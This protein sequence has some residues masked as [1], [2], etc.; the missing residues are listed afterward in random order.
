MTLVEQPSQSVWLE[1]GTA[2]GVE[3]PRCEATI[4]VRALD[5]STPSADEV[6][7]RDADGVEEAP[8]RRVAEMEPIVD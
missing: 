1:A 5:V 3:A 6:E 7:D 4:L 2:L 8:P